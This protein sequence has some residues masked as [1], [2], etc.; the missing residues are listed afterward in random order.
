ML[1]VDDNQDA[2]QSTAMLLELFGHE[3]RCAHDG[4]TAL[5]VAEDFRPDAILLD[6]G[7]PGMNGY[8][9]AEQLRRTPSTRGTL[10]IAVT[11]YGQPEDRSRAR[12]A[13]FDHHVVKPVEPETLQALLR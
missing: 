4:P 7:L 3:V 8:E 1:V 13:G 2:A 10:L 5:A 11:G 12:A 9:V 6:I